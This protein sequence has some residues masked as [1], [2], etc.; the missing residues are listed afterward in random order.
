[1]QDFTAIIE[2]ELAQWRD[3]RRRV[4]RRHAGRASVHAW[5]I[6]SRRLFALEQLLAPH[7]SSRHDPTM[8]KCLHRAFHAA[9]R[10]RDAQLA[11]PQLESLSV[12]FPAAARLA[13]HLERQL[14]HLRRAAHERIRAIKPRVL[15]DIA[16]AWRVASTQ[17]FEH[18]AARR[19]ARRLAD[20]QRVPGWWPRHD[21]SAASIH[22]QR[23][24][25]KQVR[26]MTALQSAAA[27]G[28]ARWPPLPRL[29]GWQMRLGKITDIQVLLGLMQRYGS[30]HR[31]WR[32]EVA[33]LR[34][35][36]QRGRR[37]LLD[38]LAAEFSQGNP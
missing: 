32:V 11:I 14:Q 6:A 29:A 34:R 31:K 28:A 1:M 26:Y 9:G 12:A 38:Q 7:P 35:H 5:R 18:I 4:L 23:I 27:S 22:H 2:Q 13:T 3:A 25:L 8:R 15:R 36:L 20:A 24:R 37:Q 17:R 19:A 21:S 16:A 10:L 30:R 33:P